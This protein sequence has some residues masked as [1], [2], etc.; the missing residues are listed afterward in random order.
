[1]SALNPITNTTVEL[2]RRHSGLSQRYCL[3]SPPTLQRQLQRE[4]N[5]G[6]YARRIPLELKRAH[7]VYVED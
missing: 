4:S 3:D 2:Q 1:M 5:A 6:S 7:G